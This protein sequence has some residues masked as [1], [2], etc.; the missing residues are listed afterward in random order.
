MN[1][2]FRVC[3]CV[4]SAQDKSGLEHKQRT[5]VWC[6]LKGTAQEA[7]TDFLGH[8]WTSKRVI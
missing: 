6:G 1:P 3:T 4:V 7:G 8:A 2:C 5:E